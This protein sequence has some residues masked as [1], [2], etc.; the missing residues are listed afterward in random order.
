MQDYASLMAL[1]NKEEWGLT[2]ERVWHLGHIH[3]GKAMRTVSLDGKH[4]VQVE[5]IE[6]LSGTDAWHHESAFVGSPRRGTG[7]LWSARWGLRSRLYVGVDE[8]T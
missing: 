2:S 4:S 5:H 3:K 6:S 7:F 1:E 8:M